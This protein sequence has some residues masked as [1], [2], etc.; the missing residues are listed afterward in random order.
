MITFNIAIQSIRIWIYFCLLK[1]PTGWYK[2]VPYKQKEGKGGKSKERELSYISL[3]LVFTE[4][5]VSGTPLLPPESPTRT[6]ATDCHPSK[7]KSSFKE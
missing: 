6:E 4:N 3:S 5:L 2:L 1:S 7:W